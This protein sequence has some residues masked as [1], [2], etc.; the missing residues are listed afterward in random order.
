MP[1]KSGRGSESCVRGSACQAVGH[2]P[3]AFSGP[4]LVARCNND[5]KAE[6]FLMFVSPKAQTNADRLESLLQWLV[7][8]GD[9]SEFDASRQEYRVLSAINYI[10]EFLDR[11][12]IPDESAEPEES[13]GQA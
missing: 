5:L 1:G 4:A 8:R 12:E 9:L 7:R 13:N 2:P 6:H 11:I 10:Q 3:S